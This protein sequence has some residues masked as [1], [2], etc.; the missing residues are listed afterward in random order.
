[1]NR[2]EKQRCAFCTSS[3]VQMCRVADEVPPTRG[4]KI[5]NCFCMRDS[6]VVSYHDLAMVQGFE[7]VTDTICRIS[8]TWAIAPTLGGQAAIPNHG[9]KSIKI[10]LQEFSLFTAFGSTHSCS[11]KVPRI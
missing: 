10:A 2:S 6:F 7:C 5:K 4:I 3:K 1:M 11:A 9:F 8:L